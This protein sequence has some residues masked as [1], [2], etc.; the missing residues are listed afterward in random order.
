MSKTGGS[1]SSLYAEAVVRA[2]LFIYLPLN[3]GRHLQIHHH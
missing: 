3:D 1:R 2:F